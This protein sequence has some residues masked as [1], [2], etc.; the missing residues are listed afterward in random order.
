MRGPAKR[1]YASD[2]V[3]AI[4]D[5]GAEP[6]ALGDNFVDAVGEVGA[7]A[8]WSGDALGAVGMVTAVEKVSNGG[9]RSV[10]WNGIG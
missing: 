5:R 2:V 6:G 10:D 3:P 1:W 4:G 8:D 9:K 7:V